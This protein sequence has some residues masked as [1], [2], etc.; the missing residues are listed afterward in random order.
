MCTIP[1]SYHEA[2]FTEVKRYSVTKFIFKIFVR[3]RTNQE[4]F[5]FNTF[6]S[7]FP[8]LHCGPHFSHRWFKHLF[9]PTAW[10]SIFGKLISAQVVSIEKTHPL[11]RGQ[12]LRG[13]RLR[14]HNE[15]RIFHHGKKHSHIISN[16]IHTFPHRP[17]LIFSFHQDIILQS[18][19]FL[20]AFGKRILGI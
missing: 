11:S 16:S 14:F 18:D 15:I 7:V 1:A 13:S 10:N 4:F 17:I 19:L 6:C 2:E 20:S 5:E 9:M 12:T 3:I 8:I